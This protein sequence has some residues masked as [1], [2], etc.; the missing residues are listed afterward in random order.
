MANQT[1]TQTLTLTLPDLI[2]RF[3]QSRRYLS[4]RT[5]DYYQRC[6]SGLAGFATKEGWPNPGEITREHIRDFMDYV[7]TEP[8]PEDEAASPQLP[9]GGALLRRGGERHARCLRA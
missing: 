8:H 2:A 4:P 1:V 9:G 5:V 3:I 6:L 7:A